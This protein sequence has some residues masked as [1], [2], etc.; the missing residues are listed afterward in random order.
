MNPFIEALLKGRHHSR[1]RK[2]HAFQPSPKEVNRMHII[3]QLSNADNSTHWFNKWNIFWTSTRTLS[4]STFWKKSWNELWKNS[5]NLFLNLNV[6]KWNLQTKVI[7]QSNIILALIWSSD[8]DAEVSIFR[9]TVSSICMW[10]LF[11]SWRLEK[12][13]DI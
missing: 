4:I 3:A 8:H 2:L 11:K 13:P 10:T 1:G 5:G 9:N 6:F 7:G 12:R